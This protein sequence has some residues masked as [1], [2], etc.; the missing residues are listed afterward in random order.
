VRTG[1]LITVLAIG[2]RQLKVTCW[3]LGNAFNL[4]KFVCV[5][6]CSATSCMFIIK[7]GPMI[8]SGEAGKVLNLG[9]GRQLTRG[10]SAGEH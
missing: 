10:W 8:P 5:P 2:G 1:H 9:G 6:N 3:H 4:L 7:S